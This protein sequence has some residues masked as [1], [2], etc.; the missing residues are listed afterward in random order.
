MTT[1]YWCST[2]V[3]A[4][5]P[6]TDITLW[7]RTSGL[8]IVLYVTGAI[9]LSR[10]VQWLAG[11]ITWRIDARSGPPTD[12]V[13]SE[14]AR[15]SHAV[16]QVIA[17]AVVVLIYSSAA[18]LVL[19]GLHV[20]ITSVVAPAALAGVALGFGAQRLVQDV[21]AGLLIVTERQ[22]G[23]GDVIRIS[24]LGSE[25]GVSGTVEELTLRMT[26]LRTV[27]GEVVIVA[28]GQIVQV[29]NMSRDWA[30]A[31][32]D[33]TVPSTADVQRVREILQRVGQQARDDA[34]LGPLILDPPSVVGMDSVEADGLHLRIVAR[35]L[36]GKQFDFGRELRSRVAV[37]FQAEG[38]AVAAGLNTADPV[39]TP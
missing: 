2:T 36:P 19:Q 38:I 7:V 28:N 26:R 14:A 34:A 35:T 20:P 9:L 13:R 11:R 31:V 24:P 27:D 33:V 3:L 5:A 32:V 4:V 1:N 10:F 25:T 23:F 21:L 16:T 22:Y 17:W 6:V 30:R 37:A 39:G 12:M 8:L 15:H 18:V 29:T